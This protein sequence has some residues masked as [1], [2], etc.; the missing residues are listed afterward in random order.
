MRLDG[1]QVQVHISNSGRLEELLRPENPMLLAP[2]PVGTDRNT[3]YDLVLVEAGGVLVS[4]DARVPNALLQEAIEGGRIPQ[5]AGYDTLRRE[6]P[7]GNSRIDLLLSGPAGLCYIEAK[8]VTLVENQVGLFPDAPSQRGRKHLSSLVEAVR[9][10]HRAAAV[11]V[12]QRPDARAFSPNKGADAEFCRVLARAVQ[13]GVEAYAFRCEV[14]RR[15]IEIS[16]RVQF[17]LV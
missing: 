8:S 2:A 5:F 10:G 6:A 11:F 13:H 15:G 7:L 14:D 9:Q 1:R 17:R 3:A 12:I 4:A 16:R